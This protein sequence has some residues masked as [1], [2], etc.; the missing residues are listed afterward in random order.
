MSLLLIIELLG[1]FAFAVSGAFAAMEKKLDWFGVMIIAFV[2]AID[3]GT[4]RDVL[5]GNF[6]VAWLTDARSIA[7]I[8]V[9][10]MA[11]IFFSS[12][13]RRFD[14]ILVIVDAIGLALFSIP[15]CRKR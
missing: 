7:T 10:A 3:G 13:L 14:K 5:I 12:L 2:T 1:T 4:V 6:P 15:A 8:L 9:A 11:V